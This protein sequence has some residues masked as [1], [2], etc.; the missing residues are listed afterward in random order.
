MMLVG[1]Y[2]LNMGVIEITTRLLIARMQG[3]YG[4]AVVN[5]DLDARIR[6]IRKS[7]PRGDEAR[8]K[9]AMNALGAARKHVGFRNIVAHSPLAF[10]GH[11][12]DGSRIRLQVD[13]SSR[14]QGI[15]NV[16][17]NPPELISLEE[18][19]GRVNES[20]RVARDLMEMETEVPVS[21]PP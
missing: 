15:L 4:T 20:A 16:T 1:R 10:T 14:I 19:T 7:F 17:S 5:A 18:L 13:G 3:T 8:H 6:F 11:P 2:M 12:E 9:W 21:W